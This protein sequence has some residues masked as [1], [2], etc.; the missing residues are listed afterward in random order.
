MRT[1]D[2]GVVNAIANAPG[3]PELFGVDAF[4]F[5]SAIQKRSNIFLESNGAVGIFDWSAPGVFEGHLLFSPQCRGLRAFREAS[6]MR[7]Y[8]FAHHAG[9]LWA[10]PP[11]ANE[12]G[13]R[14]VQMLG[15]DHAGFGENDLLG[16]VEY[17]QCRRFS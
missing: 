8:M 11:V 10:Q 9:M 13:R 14:L 5:T 6:R 2:A 3:V 16:P 1:F 4:D 15:F 17:F 12:A 7:D